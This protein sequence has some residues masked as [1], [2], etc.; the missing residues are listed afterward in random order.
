MGLDIFDKKS[1]DYSTEITEKDLEIFNELKV[2]LGSYNDEQKKAI[3]S[4]K[5]KIL[6]IA[7]AG[8]GKTTVLTKRIEL[9]VKYRTVNPEKI[10]A[11]TFKRKARQ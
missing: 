1:T 7:G 9:L 4:D 3:I 2:F 10:L 8:S 6:C 11:I 5:N